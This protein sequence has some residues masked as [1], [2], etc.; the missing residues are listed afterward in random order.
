MS[1][2]KQQEARPT[3]IHEGAKKF[4]P[5]ELPYIYCKGYDQWQFVS[6]KF[7]G[8]KP[9][10]YKASNGKYIAAQAEIPLPSQDGKQLEWDLGD[11]LKEKEKLTRD[12]REARE[13]LKYTA[14]TGIVSPSPEPK[15]HFGSTTK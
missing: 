4:S 7:K 13:R 6:K 9:P 12:E 2:A 11:P 5:P 10:G 8:P 3:I 1:T 14:A 15:K